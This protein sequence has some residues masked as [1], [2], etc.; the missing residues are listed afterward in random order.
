[1]LKIVAFILFIICGAVGGFT[2]SDKVRLRRD[3]CC[4]IHE[5]LQRISLLIRYRKMDM[6]EIIRELKSDMS[7]SKLDFISKL[8]DY[9]EPESDFFKLWSN[10]VECDTNIGS[11]ERTCLISF[12]RSLG[13]T[14][15]EGQLSSIEGACEVIKDIQ[16]RC[17]EEYQRKGKLYKSVGILLGTMTGIII[18]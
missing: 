2:L 9:Y 12:G 8:P 6:F 5:V 11:E 16:H 15:I 17:N 10:A 1:M 18:I 14:D 3:A 4:E 7:F 13:K